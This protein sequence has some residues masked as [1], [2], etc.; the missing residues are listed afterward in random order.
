MESL[1]VIHTY[2]YPTE[3]FLL[4]TKLEEAG[5]PVFTFEEKTI[6]MDPFLSQAIGGLKLRVP[7]KDLALAQEIVQQF[8][9]SLPRTE[10]GNEAAEKAHFEPVNTWCPK[11]DSTQVFAEKTT[12]GKGILAFLLALLLAIPWSFLKRRYRC[13]H[14]GY[15]WKGN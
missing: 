12:T 14:C 11:C 3:V 15:E 9:Q 7:E 4:K 10:E 1:V 8:Y 2:T 6:S 13:F 5:I